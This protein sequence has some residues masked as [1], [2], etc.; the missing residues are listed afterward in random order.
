MIIIE[1]PYANLEDWVAYFGHVQPPVLR[2][3][4]QELEKMRA[5]A[6]RVNGRVLAAVILQDPMMTLRVLAYIENRRRRSQNAD[7]TTIEHALMMIGIDPFF[8]EFEYLPLVED[9]LKSH[10]HALIGLLKVIHRARRASHWAREWAVIRHDL[11]VDEITV[12]TL[13]HDIAEI[14]MWCFAPSLAL[15]VRDRQAKDRTLRSSI[16]QQETY[17]LQLQQ[18]QLALA[19]AWH[20]PLLLTTLMD[21]TKADHP[22]VRNVALAV[23]LARHSANGWD[24][25]ALP[26]DFAAIAELLHISHETLMRKLG[27]EIAAEDSGKGALRRG[28][29]PLQ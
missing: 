27:L 11:D 21:R 10:P 13:L 12:A 8:R 20:L 25:P 16:A 29:E 17:N 2:H 24:D 22:R 7:I 28:A 15:Q 6:E 19:K 18:L 5:D 9:N 3:T 23:D 14:L 26:D 4:V 1:K